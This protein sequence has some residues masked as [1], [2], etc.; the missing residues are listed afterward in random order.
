MKINECMNQDVCFVKPDC[1]VY[2]AARIM[3]ENHIGCIPIC[4]DE[5]KV[6]GVIT[7]R[8]IVLRTVACDKD[9]KT[10]PV[11]EIMTTHV[12]TCECEQEVQEAEE[13]MAK[14]Q[15]RRMPIVDSSSKMVGILT[16]GDLIN[17]N[18]LKEQNVA[19]TMQ[20]IC[21]CNGNIK[22]CS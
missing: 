15:I 10:T 12:Y 5:K 21:D 19:Q 14:N 11:S 8:D 7:D 17:N 18:N 3:N 6:L 20:N 9:T 2:D 1:K 16:T 22:N 13:L 4:D